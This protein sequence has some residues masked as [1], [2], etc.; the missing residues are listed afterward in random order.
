MRQAATIA[1]AA[2]PEAVLAVLLDGPPALVVG[3]VAACTGVV[4]VAVALGQTGLLRKSEH[5]DFP[6]WS[7]ALFWPWHLF[8]RL[9]A[10]L[11][12]RTHGNPVTE[13]WPGL[14]VGGWPQDV[15]LAE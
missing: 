4:A 5:G 1:I 14:W 12:R 13:V 10:R 9:L 11:H 15:D 3:W 8:T 2:L 6:W 7:L